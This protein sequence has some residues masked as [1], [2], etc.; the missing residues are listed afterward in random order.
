MNFSM[1]CEI[2]SSF[3]TF[4]QQVAQAIHFEGLLAIALVMELFFVFIFALKT[5]FS[6]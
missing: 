5:G 3:K 6:Y 1:L 2:E 4:F